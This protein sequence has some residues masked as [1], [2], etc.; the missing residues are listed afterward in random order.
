ML[1]AQHL[2]CRVELCQ[3]GIKP[4]PNVPGIKVHEP[5]PK[6]AWHFHGVWELLIPTLHPQTDP[7]YHCQDTQ[8][9]MRAEGRQKTHYVCQSS[10]K[11]NEI[12]KLDDSWT[13]DQ[14]AAEII[15]VISKVSGNL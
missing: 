3:G 13:K 6:W 2:E 5:G 4:L 14:R 11:C 9:L 10:G 15:L 8:T 7:G 1:F 12:Q